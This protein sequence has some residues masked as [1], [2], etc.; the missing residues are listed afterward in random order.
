MQ[1]TRPDALF[2]FWSADTVAECLDGVPAEISAFLWNEIVPLQPSR[3]T[4]DGE[5]RWETPDGKSHNTNLAKH[6]KK[7]PLA[8]RRTLNEAADKHANRF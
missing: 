6:W 4:P 5:P 3:E 8:Y 2:T 7:I 1:A